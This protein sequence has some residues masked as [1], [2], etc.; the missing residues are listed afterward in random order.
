MTTRQDID[1]AMDELS[2]AVMYAIMGLFHSLLF[3]QNEEQPRGN[4]GRQHYVKG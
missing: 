2:E 1:D 3:K 4:E